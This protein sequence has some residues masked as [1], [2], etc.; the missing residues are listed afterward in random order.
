ML[1]FRL[2][3]ALLQIISVEMAQFEIEGYDGISIVEQLIF[4]FY[5]YNR[6]HPQD[7]Y[8]K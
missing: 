6:S 2:I 4:G 3:L 1:I 7:T 5:P 8:E